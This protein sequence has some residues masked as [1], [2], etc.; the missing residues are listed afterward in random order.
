MICLQSTAGWANIIL[1]Y[2]VFNLSISYYISPACTAQRVNLMASNFAE[3]QRDLLSVS[4]PFD[5]MK[6]S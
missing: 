5:K 2:Y 3:L 6:K 4:L 1:Y